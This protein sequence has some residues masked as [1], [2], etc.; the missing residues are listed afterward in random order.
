MTFQKNIFIFDLWK[1][2]SGITD[3]R[4]KPVHRF[5][6]KVRD[7]LVEIS[8]VLPPLLTVP[9]IGVTLVCRIPVRLNQAKVVPV[10]TIR[11]RNSHRNA[12]PSDLFN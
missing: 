2:V 3:F 6:Q 5:C 7:S 1:V 8:S 4:L 9:A 10:A 11:R 12:L